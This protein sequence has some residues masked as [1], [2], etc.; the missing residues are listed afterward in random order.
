MWQRQV[1]TWRAIREKDGA[2]HHTAD[3]SVSTI[4]K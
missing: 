1:T 4:F 2:Y 3:Q